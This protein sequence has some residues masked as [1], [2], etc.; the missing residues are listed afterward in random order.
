MARKKLVILHSNDL[1]GDFLPK[2]ENRPVPVRTE[3]GDSIRQLPDGTEEQDDP[4]MET[5]GIVRL[6][7]YVKKTRSEEKNVLY[8]NAGDLFRGSVIDSEYMGLST[9]DLMNLLRPDVTTVGNHE[10]DYGVAHLLFL[11]KCAHFPIINANLFISIN[12]AR[13]F[14]PYREV[15]L[16]GMRILVIGILTEEVLSSTKG[17][18][19][20]GTFIDVEEAAKEVGVI[21]D[22]YRT[23]STDLVILL[24]HIGI[25]EDRK[26]AELLHPDWGVDLIIGGHSHTMMEKPEVINGIPIVQVG[27]GS[28]QIGRFDIEYDTFWNRIVA[29]K[30]QCIPINEETAP[31]DPIME[32]LLER[33]R[34]E[35]DAKYLRVVTTFARELTHPS[36]IQ[37]TEL[38]NLYSDL[39][40]TDS[41]FDIMMMGSGAIRKEK[42]GPIVAYQDMLENTPFDD[43]LWMLKVTGEQFRRM[44]QYVFRDD[45]WEGHTEFY[46]Y[47]K[48]VRIVYRKSTHTLEELSFRGEEIRDDQEFLIAMQN[49]H[50]NNFD[51]F[52]NVPI[53]EVRKNMK[54]RVVATSVNNI[55]EEY[56]TIH[57][58]LDAH[59]EGRIVILD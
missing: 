46:Q 31:K 56:F 58:G 8:L 50:Y 36:R 4:G 2:H 21:C 37:E 54:P 14:E 45:A 40:Q 53:A 12:N 18:K 23:K 24:T 41:S 22:N 33:Y 48:G 1:H 26:L 10:V 29:L 16:D 13:L 3:G 38:G 43:V 19:V 39:L 25:E 17:E 44:I 11:E 47:S 34:G 55:V 51:E 59:V 9:I 35:T 5:G 30:W 42:L 49:Y 6:S 27:K 20:I 57:Q 7:G 15:T 28:G 52:F 32:Q